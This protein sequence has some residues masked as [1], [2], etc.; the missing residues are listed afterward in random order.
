MDDT[1]KA[2]TNALQ[3]TENRFEGGA[4]PKSDVAQAQTQLDTALAQ[5]TD[6]DVQRAQYEHAIATLLG[7]PPAAF[8]LAPQQIAAAS[9]A[10]A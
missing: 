7:K 4:S 6:I 5:E 2:Y 10:A 8:T 1:V 3:L 9:T